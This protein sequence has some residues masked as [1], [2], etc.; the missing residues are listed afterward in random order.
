MSDGKFEPFS[1][2]SN[3]TQL[4]TSKSEHTICALR[5]LQAAL[6]YADLDA[7]LPRPMRRRV[8]A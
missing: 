5:G 1:T 7:W 6:V 4:D 8:F 3:E 2:I